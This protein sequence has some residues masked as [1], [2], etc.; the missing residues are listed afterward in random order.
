[1]V[2][3]LC[4]VLKMSLKTGLG[5]DSTVHMKPTTCQSYTASSYREAEVR[6]LVFKNPHH[7]CESSR[8]RWWPPPHPSHPGG[9]CSESNCCGSMKSEW[10]MADGCL[11][12][13]SLVRLMSVAASRITAGCSSHFIMCSGVFS[14]SITY[15]VTY[16]NVSFLSF[17]Q[18]WFCSVSFVTN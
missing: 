9:R 3:P 1:M 10:V 6:R 12:C 2:R 8:E 13:D 4:K 7:Q 5:F 15:Q 14:P 17:F 11:T 16:L 18:K